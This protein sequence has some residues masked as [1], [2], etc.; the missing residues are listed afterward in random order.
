MRILA[1][2]AVALAAACHHGADAEE[3]G[4]A[5]AVAMGDYTAELE[6]DG[7]R[8]QHGITELE[9]NIIGGSNRALRTIDEYILPTLD[10]LLAASDGALTAADAYIATGV[11]LDD[12][13][14]ATLKRIR[15]LNGTLHQLRTRLAAIK[16]P[17]TDAGRDELQQALLAA[18]TALTFE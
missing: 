8:F 12:H 17:L 4:H 11:A 14:A 15:D 5:A 16:D 18:G 1:A 9:A 13:T 10:R 2:A 7:P 6:V 3:L